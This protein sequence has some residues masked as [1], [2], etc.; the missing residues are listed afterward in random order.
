LAL[1]V[2]R[3]M[4]LKKLLGAWSTMISYFHLSKSS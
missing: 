1:I 4:A 2:V 3:C